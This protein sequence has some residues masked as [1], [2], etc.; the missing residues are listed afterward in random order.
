M[1]SA[2]LHYREGQGD[3]AVIEGQAGLSGGRHVVLL[4]ASRN[5]NWSGGG[6]RMALPAWA[7]SRDGLSTL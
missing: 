1:G 7:A 6:M 5:T 2:R 3:E 4:Q